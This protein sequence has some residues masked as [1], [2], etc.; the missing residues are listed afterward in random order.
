VTDGSA[1][2]QM[3]DAP[4]QEII[5]IFFQVSGFAARVGIAN[6]PNNAVHLSNS[7]RKQGVSV[8]VRYWLC[9]TQHANGLQQKTPV[10]PR[11]P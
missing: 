6:C 8:V 3:L 1:A 10:I 4:C 9:S 11:K 5:S 2:A 7:A